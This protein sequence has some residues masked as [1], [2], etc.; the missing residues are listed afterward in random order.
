MCPKTPICSTQATALYL[1]LTFF[2]LNTVLL[3]LGTSSPGSTAPVVILATNTTLASST[4]PLLLAKPLLPFNFTDIQVPPFSSHLPLPLSH[5]QKDIM[6]AIDTTSGQY[7]SENAPAAE[8]K[9]AGNPKM[10]AVYV[11]CG[12][13][14]LIL[15]F[16][17]VKALMYRSKY[18]GY[19]W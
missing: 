4:T 17:V 5:I 6:E 2:A 19:W 3:I 9:A 12:V 7:P 13:L 18:G 8:K 11:V 10:I 15:G 14:V 16:A 1:P